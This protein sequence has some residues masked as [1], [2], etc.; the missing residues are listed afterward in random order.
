VRTANRL[1]HTN[2]DAKA[3]FNQVKEAFRMSPSP[4]VFW[5]TIKLIAKII[6][7]K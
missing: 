7:R 1:W 5:K 6:L 4:Y 3:A 2:R